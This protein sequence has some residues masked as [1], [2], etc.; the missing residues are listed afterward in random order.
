MK[1][2]LAERP[3]FHHLER[4]VE[5]HIFLCILAYHLLVSIE[6]TLRDRGGRSSWATVREALKTHQICTV[7][8][9]TDTGFVLRIRKASTPEPQHKQLYELLGVPTEIIRPK[10]MWS[11]PDRL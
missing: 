11:D 6:K 7:V 9:P 1:S 3:I 8:L 2:P 10:K 4:R 5:T